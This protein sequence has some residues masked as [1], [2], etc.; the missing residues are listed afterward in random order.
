MRARAAWLTTALLVAACQASPQPPSAAPGPSI[1][2]FTAEPPALYPGETVR[3]VPIFSGGAGVIEPDIGPVDSG[4]PVSLKPGTTPKTF[5][6]RVGDGGRSASAELPLAVAYRHLLDRVPGGLPRTD[7][8]AG[9]L[10]DGRVVL[11]GG[12]TGA[13]WEWRTEVWDPATG[14]YALAGELDIPHA[15]ATTLVD[16]KGRLLL[17][18]GHDAYG[19]L[20][21]A[22]VH[23][24]DPS[25]G[26]WTLL[27][28]PMLEE[29][30][31]HSA[32]LLPSG[33]I[34]VA[35]GDFLGKRPGSVVTEEIY[36]PG[37]A[38]P[39]RPAGGP[40]SFPRY[41]HTATTLPDGTILLA[42]GR[43]AFTG[44][45]VPVAELYDPATE[46]FT[47]IG[48]MRVGRALHV[49]A[50]LPGGRVLLAGGDTDVED[51]TPSAEVYDAADR[52]FTLVGPLHAG[53]TFHAS[54]PLASGEVLVAGGMAPD[55]ALLDTIEIF[56][57]ARQAFAVSD[58]R[59]ASGRMGLALVRLPDGS[60]LV[61]GGRTSS[62]A[63]DGV[64]GVYR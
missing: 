4:Q 5:V 7:H 50:P 54:V 17:T 2:S 55:G 28:Y 18:G 62:G 27:K 47:P 49:A 57:P 51:A 9:L 6:L 37:G 35:G 63:P 60:V 20:E 45:V 11:A 1:Q 44:V 15:E 13:G 40:M 46:T 25:T 38:A 48:D 36:D 19:P 12:L 64:A 39:R 29:R 53:R 26:G 42:G 23:A 3:L 22:L 43:S 56:D 24:F 21:S 41:G 32:T 52:T 61:H 33:E 58:G 10:P 14:E 34:L 30:Y 31:L 8:G 16:G 59:L